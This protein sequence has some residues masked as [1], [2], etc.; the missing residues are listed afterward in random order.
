[1]CSSCLCQALS[2]VT[3]SGLQS[4]APRWSWSFF[5]VEAWTSTTCSTR[6]YAHHIDYKTQRP[7]CRCTALTVHLFSWQKRCTDSRLCACV[8]VETSAAALMTILAKKQPQQ[9][10]FSLME[11]VEPS[12]PCCWRSHGY[13]CRWHLLFQLFILLV[14]TRFSFKTSPSLTWEWSENGEWSIRS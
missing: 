13:T 8:C 3:P 9:P 11:D 10:S 4:A 7:T 12:R 6:T 5:A 2:R 14:F 1:M